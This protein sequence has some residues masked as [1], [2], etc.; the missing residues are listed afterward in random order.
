[1]HEVIWGRTRHIRKL[2]SDFTGRPSGLMYNS[3][4][5]SVKLARL[6][7]FIPDEVLSPIKPNEVVL[8]LIKP[9]LQLKQPKITT[10]SKLPQTEPALQL[11]P[12]MDSDKQRLL[13][14]AW[15]TDED[16]NA[17]HKLLAKQFSRQRGLQ[18]MLTLDK[19]DRYDSSSKDF[20][21]VINVSGNHWVCASNVLSP[22]GIIYVYDSLPAC[23]INS[24]SLHRQ[25]AAIMKSKD[26]SFIVK[27]AAVQRQ[28]GRSDCGVFAI[29]FATS[30]CMRIDPN[31]LNC[32]QTLM[33]PQLIRNFEGGRLLPFHTPGKLRR[34]ERACFLSTKEVPVFCVCRL[35]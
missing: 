9:A 35:P 28:I 24:R 21:Q 32:N 6:P 22:P 8:S 13:S 30:L 10:D 33:R 17:A 12:V 3:T 5:S 11:K 19:F 4:F 25:I 23:C 26:A 2:Q 14:D 16:I 34:T 20:V 15:L 31:T 18:D 7:N 27:H 1:M 29:A